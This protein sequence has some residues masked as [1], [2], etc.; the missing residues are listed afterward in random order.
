MRLALNFFGVFQAS[1]DQK[2]IPE[3]RAKRIEALLI[4]LAMEASRPHRRE[5]LIGLLFPDMPDEAAR[6]NLRQTLTR[7]R[8]AIGDAQ[9]EPPFLL[10]SRESTQFNQASSYS[11]DV[12]QFR[13][14]LTGC[15][16]HQGSRDA[17]CVD[18]MAQAATAVSHYKGAF[19][20]G[21]FLEDSV[22]FDDW[23]LGYRQRFQALALAALD[24]LAAFHMRRGEYELAA[25]YARRQ[26]EIEPWR[27]TAQQQLMGAL[28]QAGQRNAALAAYQTFCQTVWDELGVE[29]MPETAALAEQIRD[30]AE[31]RPYQL[32][33]INQPLVGRQEEIAAL[34]AQLADPAQR[35]QTVVGPG[36][37]GKTRLTLELAW[38]AATAYLGPFMHGVFFV[39]L[40]GVAPVQAGDFNPL[41]TAVAEAIGFTFAGAEEP[42]TQLLG[43]LQDKNM[44]LVLDNIEHLMSPGRDLILALLQQTK[45]LNLLVTSRERLNL[46]EEQVL[47]LGGL[48]AAATDSAL[49]PAMALFVQRARQVAANFTLAEGNA[50]SEETVSPICQLLEGLPLAIELAAACVRLLTCPEIYTELRQN[51]DALPATAV[52]KPQRHHSL[53]AVFDYSW[54]LLTPA[55]QQTL[56]QLAIFQ[57]GFHRQ[58]ATQV[59][60]AS[61]PQLSALLDKSFLRRQPQPVGESWA[62]ARYEMLAVVRQF[63]TE[64]QKDIQQDVTEL[65]QRHGRY[66]LDFVATQEEKLEGGEQLQAVASLSQEIENIRIAWRFA[67]AQGDVKA[68]DK[69]TAALSLFFYMRSWFREGVELFTLAVE[70]LANVASAAVLAKMAARQAWFTFLLG[71]HAAAQTLFTQSIAQLRQSEDAASLAYAL[72]YLAVVLYVQRDYEA[73]WDCCT[74]ALAIGKQDQLTYLC[75]ISNNI[76]SQIAY[77]QERYEVAQNHSRTSLQLE[78]QLGNRWSM[79]FSLVNLGRVAYALGDFAKARKHYEESLAI[80]KAMEDARGQGL[81]CLYLG[82]TAVASQDYSEATT[83]YQHSLAIFRQI[84]DKATVEKLHGR[85]ASVPQSDEE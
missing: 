39:P 7:L 49:N 23:L 10:T 15:E 21:F 81:C 43:Y 17:G 58:A 31:E 16:Q 28:A 67:V 82:D 38:Q 68:L 66:F 77:L 54:Q 79:G 3:S 52:D 35:L 12:I 44:L 51:L 22:A 34:T 33:S 13:D 73:A 27:E 36:G 47:T 45:S 76:L 56:T 24:E 69:A 63:A 14:D 6:T 85:L 84:G 50:C 71:D 5:T 40:A 4:Y 37:M 41:V 55:E 2:P 30:V 11:L 29:P 60:Q 46:A 83:N 62:Q 78:Q 75:A 65:R 53:R 72:N 64:R 48:P 18:C 9:A 32:P 8:R 80:R 57:G 74:E 70:Q 1:V 20:D 42:Q 26:L 19:L 25:T 59:A 61:L